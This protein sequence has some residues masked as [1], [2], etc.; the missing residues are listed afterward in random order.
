MLVYL[1]MQ[2]HPIKFI[3]PK[4]EIEAAFFY[5]DELQWFKG[6]VRKLNF[7]GHDEKGR[8]VN[9]WIDYNDGETV[10]DAFFYDCDFNLNI[11]GDAWRFTGTIALLMS[12]VIQNQHDWCS[13]SSE[14]SSSD[15]SD[16][17]SEAGGE[18]QDTKKRTWLKFIYDAL[19][20]MNTL[21]L[22]ILTFHFVLLN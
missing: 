17:E 10:P 3:K 20:V 15:I 1:Q 8:F 18:S 6:T 2:V 14:S 11:R 13:S 22:S 21:M 9:C 4:T 5:G 16:N 19:P 12:L 7:Y